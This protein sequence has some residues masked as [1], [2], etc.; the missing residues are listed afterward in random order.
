MFVSASAADASGA[1]VP[2]RAAGSSVAADAAATS[3]APP[4]TF[5]PLSPARILNTR[6]GTGGVFGAVAGDTTISFPA[7]GVGGVPANATSVVLNVT[8]AGPTSAGYL[9]VFPHGAT[10]PDASNL[11][12][13]AGR[14]VANMVVARVGVGGRVDVYNFGGTLDIIADV[15]GYYVDGLQAGRY[16]PLLPWRTFDT[17]TNR[18]INTNVPIPIGPNDVLSVSFSLPQIDVNH[19]SALLLNVTA[20]RPTV[21]GYLTVYPWLDPRPDASSLNFTK[22]QT[23]ANA[24]V[25]KLGRSNGT[26]AYSIYNAFGSTDVL[27]DVI[28]F[29]DDNTTQPISWPSAY[30]AL[31]APARVYNT[32]QPGIGPFGPKATRYTSVVGAGGAPPGAVAVSMNVTATATTTAGYLAVWSAGSSHPEVST[33]NWSANDTVPNAATVL[34]PN[35]G[36]RLGQLAMYNDTGD[37]DV[38]FDVAGYFYPVDLLS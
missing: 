38:L 30:R 36:P 9:T 11:N 4:A 33:V 27:I 6:D 25:V 13:V 20:T 18:R 15:T 37:V 28:G 34:V 5:V 19:V 17:R 1:E 2:D 22:D 14:T 23:V 35:F 10:R 16:Y 31:D 8:A 7:V 24:V 29:F 3:L 26:A 32:R 12:V 21:G